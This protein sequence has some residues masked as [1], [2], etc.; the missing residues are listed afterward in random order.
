MVRHLDINHL[1]SRRYLMEFRFRF[2]DLFGKQSERVNELSHGL[3][4]G[5]WFG[6]WFDGHAPFFLREGGRYITIDL[7]N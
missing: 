4:I 5:S 7:A 2:H 1:S 6:K 3:K